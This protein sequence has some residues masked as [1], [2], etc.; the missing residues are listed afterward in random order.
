M[1]PPAAQQAAHQA[2]RIPSWLLATALVGFAGGTYAYVLKQLGGNLNET[3]EAEAARQ[4]A[5]ERRSQQQSK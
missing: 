3:L 1:S 2:T 4:E 5:L